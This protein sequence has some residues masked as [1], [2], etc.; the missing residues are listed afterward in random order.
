MTESLPLKGHTVLFTGKLATANRRQSQALVE[1]AGGVAVDNLSKSVTLVVVGMLGWA[2]LP[3]GKVSEKL[4]KAEA[5]QKSGQALEVISE[6]EFLRRLGQHSGHGTAGQWQASGT[7]AQ[8]AQ[9][10]R[11][12]ETL[13][14]RW[15][16]FGL[17]QVKNDQ[18]DFQDLVSLR[19]IAK[20]IGDGLSTKQLAKALNELQR[21]VPDLQRPFA[22]ARIIQDSGRD[23]VIELQGAKMTTQGQLLL[24]FEAQPQAAPD[25]LVSQKSSTPEKAWA[26]IEE[27]L[28]HEEEQNWSEAR[29]SYQQALDLA[30][31]IAEAHCYLGNVLH[32]LQEYQ[33]AVEHYHR[34]LDFNP[35]FSDAWYNLACTLEELDQSAEAIKALKQVLTLDPDYADAHFNLARLLVRAGNPQEAVTYWKNYLQFDKDSQWAK[36]AKRQ[37]LCY[38]IDNR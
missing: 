15:S 32:Q 10:L 29:R 31:D 9:L 36:M 25:P 34:A 35:D 22:Q 27:G 3:D 38:E 5:L 37:L 24:D 20:L 16:Q 4:L 2:L 11:V 18:V 19:A 23:I 28:T 13:I 1:A 30:P 17:I 33:E 6:A 8:A 21:L 26:L 14:R 12:D 7:V